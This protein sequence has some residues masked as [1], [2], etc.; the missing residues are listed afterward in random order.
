MGNTTRYSKARPATPADILAAIQ[1]KVKNGESGL[2]GLTGEQ[3]TQGPPGEQGLQ[4]VPGEIGPR[5]PKGDP[6][7]DGRDGVDGK[8]G[9][10]GQQGVQGKPGERGPEGKRGAMGVQGP[11]G[12]MPEHQWREVSRG[13]FEIRF[14]EAPSVWGDW[15]PLYKNEIIKKYIGGGGGSSQTGVTK[16]TSTDGSVTIAPAGGTGEVDLSVDSA[17]DAEQIITSRIAGENMSAFRAV[18]LKNGEVFLA[19]KDSMA[20][21]CSLLGITL[22]A[23]TIGNAVKVVELGEINTSASWTVNAAV[24]VDSNGNLTQTAPT[25]DTLAIVGWASAS[26]TI[27]VDRD[28][29][30]IEIL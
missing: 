17:T 3:G 28:K 26:Q 7:R 13:N 11:M 4:G 6:G 8:D 20:E 12:P 9:A 16:I 18:Y 5:G 14:E 22:Q 15:I 27:Y 10:T 21:M 1:A 19:D 25:T 23:A 24:F 2:P 30:P 29:N